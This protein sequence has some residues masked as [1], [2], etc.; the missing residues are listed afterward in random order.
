MPFWRDMYLV[1]PVTLDTYSMSPCRSA[2]EGCLCFFSPGIRDV[3]KKTKRPIICR[4]RKKHRSM[5]GRQVLSENAC[6][7]SRCISK[8]RCGLPTLRIHLLNSAWTSSYRVSDLIHHLAW[9]EPLPGTW[10]SL[11][12][13]LRL[14]SSPNLKGAPPRYLTKFKRPSK[15]ATLA[16]LVLNLT[17]LKYWASSN[18]KY[19]V[20]KT[21]VTVVKE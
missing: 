12:G 1:D 6:K 15:F 5:T 11:S 17:P 4:K 21:E 9:K 19:V 8:K 3:H 10:L 20:P 13:R 18:Y 16:S 14:D 7:I 2:N